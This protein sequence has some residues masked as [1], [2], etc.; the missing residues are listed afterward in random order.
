MTQLSKSA[1]K[2]QHYLDE[3]ALPFDVLE[4]PDS[5]RSSAEAA[6]ALAC[7]EG[8]IVKSLVFSADSTGS[9]VLV[10]ASGTNRVDEGRVAEALGDGIARPD[11]KFVKKRTGFSIGGVAPIGHKEACTVFV[12]QDLLQY[13]IVWAAAGTP[14]AVFKID[15]P[16]TDILGAHTVMAVSS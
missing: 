13:D 6:S 16:I 2:F 4:L 5:T 14:S 11:A 1:R 10:L 12:D 15:R 9:P 3:R 8:Q 7:N